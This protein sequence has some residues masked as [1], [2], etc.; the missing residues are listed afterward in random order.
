H[1]GRASSVEQER[2]CGEGT[3]GGDWGLGES[4]HG[5]DSR[6]FLRAFFTGHTCSQITEGLGPHIVETGATRLAIV[7]IQP[8]AISSRARTNHSL[9]N[10]SRSRGICSCAAKL[11][12]STSWPAGR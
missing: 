5:L 2:R 7:P 3:G 10:D 8:K 4:Y 12:T 9:A 1:V 6:I 11:I